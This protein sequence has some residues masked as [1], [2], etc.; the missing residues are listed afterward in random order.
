MKT[1]AK[2][3]IGA[4]VLGLLA[5]PGLARAQEHRVRDLE[6]LPSPMEAL[7]DLQNTGRMAF[8]M[9]DVNHDG[10]VS[11]QEAIDVNNLL[12]GGFFFRADADGN[13]TVTQEE[14]KGVTDKYLNQN[15]WLRYVVDS[16]R[17]QAKQKN[18]QNSNQANPFQSIAALLDSNGDK[19][20]QATELRQMVQ[21]TTQSYFAAADTNRDGQLSP[22]EANASVAGAVRAIA[23]ASFQ[24]ADADNNGQL[25]RA[26]YDKA[27]IEPANV[28][29]QILDLNHDGQL[30]QQELQQVERVIAS[31][32]KMMQLPEPANSPTNLI[33]SGKLPREA[34]PVPNFT[35]PGAG[36]NRPQPVPP[37]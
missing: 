19:Q 23:Q 10:Q 2:F 3:G 36:Q 1:Y 26:E 11:Q 35:V 7:R 33:E 29:F 18:A 28:A 30:S 21:T 5:V 37:R 22:S 32:I 16:L 25:S 15:P 13:G 6:S 12:I 34:A 27:I 14:M 31:Q 4:L 17:A 9:A 8:M 24:Q 20:I